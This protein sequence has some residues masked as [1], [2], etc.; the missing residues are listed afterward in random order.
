MYKPHKSER[1]P[2]GTRRPERIDNNWNLTALARKTA[3]T[4][5]E[6]GVARK[7]RSSNLYERY[8]W[9]T[10]S[11]TAV[12][13]NAVDDGNG[14]FGDIGLNP[15]KAHTIPATVDWHAADRRWEIKATPSTRG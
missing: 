11:I 4:H 6:V 9:S 8:T 7:V 2:E 5:T 15:E 1:P 3:N 12:M 13:N 14:Y 10:W